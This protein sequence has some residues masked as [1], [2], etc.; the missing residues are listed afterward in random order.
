MLGLCAAEG[1]GVIPWSPL[2][3]GKLA[4]PW[5]GQGSTLRDQTDPVSVGLYKRNEELD[6][7]VVERLTEVAAARGLPQAQV[8]LAWLLHKPVVTSAIVGTTK[9]EQLDDA[10]A[11]VDLGLSAEE[12]SALEE[13]Y[14]PHGWIA[15]A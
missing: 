6:R 13:P 12:I 10:L 1:V 5:V 4:R 15:G 14:R 11:A 7:P 8:A 9:V 3:R 2:A